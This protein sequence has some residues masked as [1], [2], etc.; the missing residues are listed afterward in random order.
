MHDE[1]PFI[2]RRFFKSLLRRYF[3]IVNIGNTRPM[4]NLLGHSW[5]NLRLMASTIFICFYQLTQHRGPSKF[6]LERSPTNPFNFYVNF[7]KKTTNQIWRAKF[8]FFCRFSDSV[9]VKIPHWR[10]AAA[11]N[12][13]WVF[14]F[15]LIDYSDRQASR[16]APFKKENWLT[17][18]VQLYKILESEQSRICRFKNQ[19]QFLCPSSGISNY[20][21]F[22]LT[23]FTRIIEAIF[24]SKYKS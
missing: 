18:G 23:L 5:L 21:D 14:I 10:L 8:A 13:F 7:K 9:I 2:N 19:R 11:K 6:G 24:G 3:V 20:I 15:I 17:D 22:D 12:S 4:W 1:F 16:D